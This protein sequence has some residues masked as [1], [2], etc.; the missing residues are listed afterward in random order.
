MNHC[1]KRE[2]YPQFA[3]QPCYYLLSM[4]IMMWIKYAYCY[5]KYVLRKISGSH[6][7]LQVRVTLNDESK[8]LKHALKNIQPTYSR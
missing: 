1:C 2:A 8:M 3:Q 6:G 7:C 5:D 4:K